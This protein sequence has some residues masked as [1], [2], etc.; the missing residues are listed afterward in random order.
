MLVLDLKEA[1]AKKHTS[2]DGAL[3]ALVA[4]ALEH[5]SN[6]GNARQGLLED[7]A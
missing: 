6:N 5:G 1:Q 2:T 4:G 7:A 3:S